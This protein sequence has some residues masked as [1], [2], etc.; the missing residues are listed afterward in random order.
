MSVTV[1]ITV[2]DI[3]TQLLTYN[4]IRLYRADTLGGSYTVQVTESLV[5]DDYYY[6]I[7]DASGTLNHWYK[8]TFYHTVSTAESD[9]SL[10]FRVDGVT[11]LRAIQKAM[12]DYNAGFVMVA[13]GVG[14][15][16]SLITN[17]TRIRSTAFRDD[18]F[19]GSWVYVSTGAR[20]EEDSIVVA[21]DVSLGDL[22]I[23][24]I[25]TGDLAVG[26]EFELHRLAQRQVWNDAF[27]RAMARYYYTDR[28]PI[29]GVS[30]QE[31][32]DLAEL[33]WVRTED[34]IFDVTHYPVSGQDIEKSYGVDGKWW[35]PRQ[36]REKIVLAIHPATTDTLYL[37][38]VRPMPSLYTDAAVAP[39]PCAEELA[40]A[41]T[42]DEVL[43]WL[44]KYGG[45]EERS[46]WGKQ[47]GRFR[48]ELLRLLD[49]YRP[50]PRHGPAQL[51]HIPVVHRPTQAR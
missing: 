12:A 20:A 15:T 37:Y 29:P 32:Y 22:T 42:Y 40:A 43:G 1:R 30:G 11:R 2:E 10:A 17:D 27:N 8:Y 41:L 31:E 9:F 39:L 28:V 14:D 46:S 48:P 4:S 51:P 36:D 21:S 47:K 45:V 44:Y 33:P 7:S 19:K 49:K 3:A 38:T 50:R 24:P 34:D 13:S 26:D 16:S 25:L 18:R 6:T 23:D 5:A 35:K